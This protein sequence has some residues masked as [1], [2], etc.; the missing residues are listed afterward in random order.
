MLPAM[1][2][3]FITRRFIGE[4]DPNLEKVYTFTTIM[5]NEAILFEILD[6][7]SGQLNVSTKTIFVYVS[8]FVIRHVMFILFIS[9]NK[10]KRFFFLLSLTAIHYNIFFSS[11]GCFLFGISFFCLRD[12]FH[13][14]VTMQISSQT[15]DGPT[16]SFSCI[17]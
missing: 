12:R 11:F 13:R 6:A 16:L 7:K 2:V 8:F 4:Y 5:D 10:T 17:R 15:L 3:R 9:I 1:V 14:R